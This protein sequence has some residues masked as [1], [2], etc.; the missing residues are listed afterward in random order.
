VSISFS[1]YASYLNAGCRNIESFVVQ[2]AVVSKFKVGARG[3][4]VDSGVK[5]HSLGGSD[6]CA[7]VKVGWR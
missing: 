3:G 2:G 4:G 1:I 7:K 5:A 6:D